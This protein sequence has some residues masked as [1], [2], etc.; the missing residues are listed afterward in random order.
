ML[1]IF[2]WDGTLI[3][4]IDK[5]IRC[6][7]GA[8]NDVGLEKRSDE[9]VRTIIGLGLPQAI[10]QL[11]PAIAEPE[12][13]L[14]CERY[15]AHFIEADQVPCEF[16]PGV[17]S[18][19]EQL[20]GDG[21]QLAVATGKSRRGLDRVLHNLSMQDFFDASRCADETQSKP[22]PLMLE[23]LLNE[24]KVDRNQAV[25]VGDTEYDLQM[26]T[27]ARLKSIAVSYGAHRRDRLE[28]HSPHLLIDYFEQ[29][30]AWSKQ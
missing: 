16:F 11:F 29:L 15:S 8:I 19:L 27:N 14:L 2:D 26:A 10:R 6:M 17:M 5:I 13:L 20:R 12:M 3:D 25:M 18:C 24:L 1:F 23:Q 9:Q 21:H 30:L 7:H 4:S 22:H 28:A